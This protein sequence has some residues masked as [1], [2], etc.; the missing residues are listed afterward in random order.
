MGQLQ[1]KAEG[2][3][4]NQASMPWIADLLT[5]LFFSALAFLK[6]LLNPTNSHHMV[7]TTVR[8]FSMNKNEHLLSLVRM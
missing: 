7:N 6:T 1:A 2:R 8:V 4:G 3:D 5:R